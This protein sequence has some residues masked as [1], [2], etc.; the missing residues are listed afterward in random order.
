MPSLQD[1]V[2]AKAEEQLRIFG[3]ELIHRAGVLLR[4][5][6][7]TIISASVVFQHFFCRRSFAEFD[8]QNAA[9]AALLLSCK[10]EETHRK[11]RDVIVVFH[12]LQMRTHEDKGQLAYT[13]RPT[14]FLDAG[15]KEYQEMK[16][17]VVRAERHMLRELGFEVAL[18]QEHP[19][20][21]VLQF[22]GALAVQSSSLTQKAWNYLND[23]LRTGLICAYD[24][25]QIAAASIYLSARDVGC[26]LPSQPPW[27][28]AIDTDLKD[29]QHAAKAILALYKRPPAQY[30]FVPRRKK[31]ASEKM[32]EPPMTPFAETPAPAKSPSDEDGDAEAVASISREETA[33]VLDPG[34]IAEMLT[35][36]RENS[37]APPPATAPSLGKESSSKGRGLNHVAAADDDRGRTRVPD[38]DKGKTR[39]ADDD[40]GKSRTGDDDRGKAR[41][42]ERDREKER[43]RR[44]E[45]DREREREKRQGRGKRGT[46]SDSSSGSRKKQRQRGARDRR[47]K[48][49]VSDSSDSS[50]RPAK[51]RKVK[52]SDL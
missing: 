15:C 39:A 10:L 17:E 7:I 22:V 30:I 20:K 21:Y 24:S 3:A 1:G 19:H 6:Q 48:R 38:D 25:R 29:V 4:V 16:Q 37:G 35:E 40:R 2:D 47:P 34:R 8:V 33:E 49:S 18:L 44:R 12:R 46:R 51:R 11:L 42:A 45:Q 13:G 43:D 14:P 31:P 23:A 32:P 50:Y 41:K 5:P 36:R 27:W 52:D 9:C 28:Q 26:K